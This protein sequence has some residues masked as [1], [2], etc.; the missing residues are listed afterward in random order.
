MCMQIG[1]IKINMAECIAGE[2]MADTMT[3]GIGMDVFIIEVS[4]FKVISFNN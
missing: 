2:G 3:R 4:N 1:V